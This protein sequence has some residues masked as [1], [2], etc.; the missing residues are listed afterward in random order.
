M[1]QISLA[2]LDVVSILAGLVVSFGLTGRFTDPRSRLHLIDQPNHRSLHEQPTPRSGGIAILAGLVV[3]S[4][5]GATAWQLPI[6]FAWVAAGGLGLAAVS[7][8]D[9]LRGVR[10]LYRLLVHFAAAALLPIAGYGVQRMVLPGIEL[11]LPAGLGVTLSLLFTVWMVNLYNFMD[12]MDG[13]A[14][15]MAVFGFGAYGILGYLAGEPA[16]GWAALAVVAAAMGFLVFNFP[17]ARIFMGDVG[18]AVLGYLA[19]VFALWADRQGIAPLW[20]SVLVFS[21]FV[22]DA[23]V[24]LFRRALRGEPLWEAHRSHYYQRLVR[25]GWGHRRTVIWEYGV[26]AM[27]AAAGVVAVRMSVPGQWTVLGGA[28]TVLIAAMVWVDRRA[29]FS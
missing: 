18:S 1:S 15:G 13:F 19:A 28:T 27:C 23:T 11:S 29:P 24:T 14:G 2:I 10:P 20:V 9:D 25:S 26:M 12:G 3:A 16:F 17:P 7:F 4:A 21:P 22:V 5:V 8:L 6:E